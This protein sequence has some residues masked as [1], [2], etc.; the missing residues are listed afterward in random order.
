MKAAAPTARE[1]WVAYEGREFQV[2]VGED[3]HFY[4][5]D[6]AGHID[7]EH[8]ALPTTARRITGDGRLGISTAGSIAQSVIPAALSFVPVVGPVLGPLASV[9]GS[10]VSGM[11]GGNDPTPITALQDKVISLR[12]GILAA[13]Q[14]LG[15]SDQMPT[16]PAGK[17]YIHSWQALPILLELWPNNASIADPNHWI[18]DWAGVNCPG[19]G[20]IRKCFYA[21]I[22]KLTPIFQAKTSSAHDYSITQ[23]IMRQITGGSVAPS[24]IP[25]G[26]VSPTGVPSGYGGSPS[27]SGGVTGGAINYGSPLDMSSGG[28]GATA[29]GAIQSADILGGLPGWSLPLLLVGIPLTIALVAGGKPPP[30]AANVNRG[31]RKHV[32]KRR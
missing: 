16:L 4:L 22:N 27:S 1:I 26:N 2:F 13:N 5:H 25:S 3:G 9:I 31:A 10:M 11:F 18:C 23:S 28:P 6:P 7:A 17:T 8:M 30:R 24:A 20:N 12:Q 15:V 32:S 14:A 29:P 21:A 19:C